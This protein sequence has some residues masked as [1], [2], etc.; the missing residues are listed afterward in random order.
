MCDV[1]NEMAKDKIAFKG[2]NIYATLGKESPL[3]VIGFMLK[4]KK[5]LVLL[6]DK[7]LSNA[8][9]KTLN[10]LR[11]FWHSK[12][13][14]VRIKDAID[15]IYCAEAPKDALKTLSESKLTDYIEKNKLSKK[16]ALKP[17]TLKEIKHLKIMK[18]KDEVIKAA[19]EKYFAQKDD[20]TSSNA[21]NKISGKATSKKSISKK[22][23]AANAAP[24]KKDEKPALTMFDNQLLDVKA[25]K[26]NIVFIF[27]PS[28]AEIKLDKEYEYMFS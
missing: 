13:G 16:D 12:M 7:N 24:A 22:D 23:I 27:S 6:V 20:N 15:G 3:P 21:K 17:E 4:G 14:K 19:I 18:Q 1:M 28:K 11:E 26:N 10:D 8:K 2:V 5:S 25:E 9:P